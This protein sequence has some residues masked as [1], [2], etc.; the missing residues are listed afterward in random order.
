MKR[1]TQLL[2]QWTAVLLLLPMATHAI[3]PEKS[4]LFLHVQVDALLQHPIVQHIQKRARED[5]SKEQKAVDNVLGES[6]RQQLKSLTLY[7]IA[8]EHQQPDLTLVLRGPFDPTVRSAIFQA[9]TDK[10][11]TVE[12]KGQVRVASL[13]IEDDEEKATD[14]SDKDA[15]Q[16]TEKKDGNV[17]VKVSFRTNAELGKHL[18]VFELPSG[19]VVAVTQLDQVD[20][21]L[22]GKVKA[23]EE[24][25]PRLLTARVDTSKALAAMGVDVNELKGGTDFQSET[26]SQIRT[27]VTSLQDAKGDLLLEIQAEA[28]NEQTA[29]QLRNVAQGLMA[30]Q[31]LAANSEEGLLGQLLNQVQINQNKEMLS[32]SVRLGAA[33][34]DSLLDKHRQETLDDDDEQE[35]KAS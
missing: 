10:G 30:L 17:E 29:T 27:L 18:Y 14:Q 31:A 8:G 21:W 35:H 6:F 24:R 34:V 16:T 12:K 23:P 3:S 19:D 11:A 1:L 7:G 15:S 32:I 25:Q 2:Y 28:T 13:P 20:A 26:M 4:P 33:W 9:L 5:M 22:A